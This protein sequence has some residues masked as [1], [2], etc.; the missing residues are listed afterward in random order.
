MVSAQ[1]TPSV[2]IGITTYNRPFVVDTV[3]K[4]K[5]FT[6]YAKI[7]VVDDCSHVINRPSG[8]TYIRL[9]ENVGVAKAKNKCLEM[10]EDCD[11]IFLFDD[12]TYPI[13]EGWDQAYIKASQDSRQGHL[14]FTFPKLYNGISNGNDYAGI[15]R[16]LSVYKKGCGCMIMV[17]KEALQRVGGMSAKYK[18]YG[19]EH[20]GW[21]YRMAN[22]GV[23]KYAFVDV[24][25]SLEL[26]YSADYW[27]EVQCSVG[28]AKRDNMAYNVTLLEREKNQGL[29]KPYKPTRSVDIPSHLHGKILLDW[30]EENAYYLR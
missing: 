15:Y 21:S 14:C 28:S 29:W 10:L 19:C 27:A 9:G 30:V 16:G 2:G 8:V 12:D 22:A 23:N 4:I 6:P 25:N 20:L 13:T 5:Q 3:A 11:Y 7:V 17:T 1:V 18:R 26:L 24:P